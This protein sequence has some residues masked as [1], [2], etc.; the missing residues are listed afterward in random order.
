MLITQQQKL[1][2]IKLQFIPICALP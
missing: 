2:N 1:I